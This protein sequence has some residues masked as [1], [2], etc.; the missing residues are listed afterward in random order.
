M[1][2]CTNS[3][4]DNTDE[5]NFE[6]AMEMIALGNLQQ[7]EALI[8]AHQDSQ[9]DKNYTSHYNSN[10]NYLPSSNRSHYT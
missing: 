5:E 4:I 2:I 9:S 10:S 7:I 6:E 1:A 8:K 3:V